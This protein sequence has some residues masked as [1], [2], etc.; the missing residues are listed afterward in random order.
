MI[1]RFKVCCIS[2]EEEARMAIEYGASAI[3]L[4]AK[5]PSGP[6][7]IPDELIRQI[8][9]TVPPPVATFML[10]SETVVNEIIEHHHRT[11]TN[12]IQIV[13]AISSGSYA[14]LKSALPNVKI[15]Q[16][17]HVID[18]RSV[19]EALR[20]SEMVDAI[21]LDSGNPK[22]KIKELGGTGRVHNWKLSR[23][24]RDK[25]KCPVFLAGGLNPD[26][27]RQAIDEVQPFAVDVCSGV[28]TDGHLD[29]KKLELFIKNAHGTRM[30]K[31]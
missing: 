28:R 9:K 20:I 17:I 23:Q 26:N 2:N 1:T 24:I 10:T 21:L 16:V 7:P 19:D 14:E 3:G 15:V 29:R 27:V 8:A 12:T 6:G 22:L 18:D 25:S 11:N 13:D 4:V 31:D 5:M 30:E